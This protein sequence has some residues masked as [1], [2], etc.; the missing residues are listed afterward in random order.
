M[1][2]PKKHSSGARPAEEQV[3]RRSDTFDPRAEPDDASSDVRQRATS[4]AI[5][6]PRAGRSETRAF[7]RVESSE[8]NVKN[9]EPDYK[10][11]QELQRQHEVDAA[12]ISDLSSE[13]VRLEDRAKRA[14]EALRAALAALEKIREAEKDVA[15]IVK[16]L[17]PKG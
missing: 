5:P 4:G 12:K 14:E 10:T 7:G 6:T 9:A 3:R 2:R 8:S 15:A 17:E 13:V 1:D 11:P 16:A